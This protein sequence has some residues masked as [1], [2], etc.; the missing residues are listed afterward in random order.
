MA[1]SHIVL[2]DGIILRFEG[3][4]P[5]VAKL[6]AQDAYF[7]HED[8]NTSFLYHSEVNHLK[9]IEGIVIMRI[10]NGWVKTYMKK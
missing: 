5:I 1:A 7:V 8:A 4:G 10:Y 6:F 2:K 9:V 3:K